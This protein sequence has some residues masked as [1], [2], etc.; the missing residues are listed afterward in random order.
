[1]MKQTLWIMALILICSASAH[2]APPQRIVSLAPN[3]TEIVY[4]MG[5]GDRVVAVTDYCDYPADAKKK[6]RV[7][8]FSTPSLEAVVA[9]RP[10]LVLMTEDGNPREFGERLQGMGVR[11]YVFR[12]RRVHDLPKGIRDLGAALEAPK[13]ASA[14]ADRIE[15]RLQYYASRAKATRSAGIRKVLF[16]VQPEPPIIAG[17]QTL[18]DDCFKILG[19]QNVASDAPAGYPKYSVETIISRA[20]DM[21]LLGPMAGSAR[22][23][24]EAQTR[25]LFAKLGALEAVKKGR[26]CHTTDVV[27]RLGPRIVDGLR[28]IASCTGRL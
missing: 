16:L 13:E 1:M 23:D 24:P 25:S 7:G 4:D 28:E 21:L 19:L 5:L 18:I 26:V 15:R 20:P 6:P 9:A 11:I 3:L 14:S 17:P 22:T 2:A 8:G 27:F 12:T 10:D